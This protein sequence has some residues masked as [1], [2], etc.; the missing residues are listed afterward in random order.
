M[1]KQKLKEISKLP[2]VNV[3][4]IKAQRQDLN[5][6]PVRSQMPYSFCHILLVLGLPWLDFKEKLVSFF[7]EMRKEETFS[8]TFP[9]EN[10]TDFTSDS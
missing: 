6:A 2:S 8:D 3:A 5:L 10:S 9:T 4:Q 7:L 1:S